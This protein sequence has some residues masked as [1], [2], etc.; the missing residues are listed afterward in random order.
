V[1]GWK[2]SATSDTRAVMPLGKGAQPSARPVLTTGA[3]GGRTGAK[4]TTARDTPGM[5][6]GRGVPLQEISG[7]SGK[8][9]PSPI[10]PAKLR[11]SRGSTSRGSMVVVRDSV[12]GDGEAGGGLRPA[13]FAHDPRCIPALARPQRSLLA[14]ESR[15]SC[16]D[17]RA[18]SLLPSSIALLLFSTPPFPRSFS[19]PCCECILTRA[20]RAG[21]KDKENMAARLS[22]MS[23]RLSSAST[24]RGS[25]ASFVAAASARCTS[26]LVP[27]SLQRTHASV[28]KA[29][30]C[31]S[32][33]VWPVGFFAIADCSWLT[34]PAPS[35]LAGPAR[36]MKTMMRSPNKGVLLLF[37]TH[38]SG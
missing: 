35:R 6:A 15:F 3:G 14:M 28:P 12:S 5:Q 20:A 13:R 1:R 7:N 18:Q 38:S 4:G 37:G 2:S 29:L 17:H 23:S 30:R 9:P 27:A 10:T 34:A 26:T 8:K 25:G 33:A 21:T 11:N 22:G 24:V 19:R 32:R 16:G 36:Y 31:A